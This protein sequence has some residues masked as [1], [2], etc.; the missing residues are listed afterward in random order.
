MIACFDSSPFVKRYVSESG[1]EVDM[2]P[3]LLKPQSDRVSY[4]CIVRSELSGG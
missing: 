2:N 4:A 1:T 3:I